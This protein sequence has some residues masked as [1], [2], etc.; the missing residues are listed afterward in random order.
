MF[1]RANRNQKD[2][3][4]SDKHISEE[5]H[6]DE[7]INLNTSIGNQA[8]IENIL[9]LKKFE[10]IIPDPDDSGSEKGSDSGNLI[11]NKYKN[12]PLLDLPLLNP[13]PELSESKKES[14]HIKFN[15]M[16]DDDSEDNDSLRQENKPDKSG[17]GFIAGIIASV[18]Q[19]NYGGSDEIEDNISEL[20]PKAGKKK[21][22]EDTE[23]N[24]L[25]IDTGPKKEE[26]EEIL[27]E[28]A[29]SQNLL[30]PGE[31]A[32]PEGQAGDRQNPPGPNEFDDSD[33][34]GTGST[35]DYKLSYSSADEKSEKYISN[36]K[37]R[38]PSKQV[39]E[40]KD[41]VEGMDA[42]DPDKKWKEEGLEYIR[43]L[44]NT[45][46]DFIGK[47]MKRLKNWNFAAQRMEDT[48]KNV[49]G[50]RKFLS[51]LSWGAGLTI[52]KILP[53]LSLGPVFKYFADKRAKKRFS[54]MQKKR[55]HDQI[56]GWNGRKFDP[57]ADKG[58]D[59]IADFRRVPTVWS[60]LTAEKAE[61]ENGKPLDP[62]ISIMISQPKAGSNK[63]MQGRNVGHAMLGIEYS[64]FSRMTGR[65]ERYDLQ[66]GFYPSANYA[67]RPSTIMMGLY[68]D[69]VVPGQL[70]DDAGHKYDISR[71]YPAKQRQVNEIF[72]AS[73][74]YADKGYQIYNRNCTTFVKEMVVD[75]AHLAI[76]DDVFKMTEVRKSSMGNLG[77][78][79]ASSV[80]SNAMAGASNIFMDNR[81]TYDPT[82]SGFG[83][84]QATQEEFT[85]YQ[86][87]LKNE[88]AHSHM[89]YSPAQTGENLRRASGEHEGQIGSYHY[90]KPLLDA[91]GDRI[92]SP[93]RLK[94]AATDMGKDLMELVS[95]VC[96]PE[97]R[98]E[99]PSEAYNTML[100]LPA[101]GASMDPI[102]R[103]IDD[104]TKEKKID[105]GDVSPSD[106][107]PDDL[108]RST[109]QEISENIRLVSKLLTKYL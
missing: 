51:F 9:D 104:Y 70:K 75:H 73:E 46:P 96:P 22:L 12:K 11:I 64:R 84:K 1:S 10:E 82:Y 45:S 32:P 42:L 53:L 18:N 47:E 21:R 94:T 69:A 17:P 87:S 3:Q 102:D 60:H 107:L 106:A 59:V 88:G 65:Y 89:T 28:M 66:Y 52:G 67:D 77:L 86:E 35:Y 4:Q 26:Q 61:D 57:N 63:T 95:T 71:T 43:K 6:A 58:K 27:N 72:K 83:N 90:D 92:T 98:T 5:A 41:T 101:M 8:M 50:W 100:L 103:K 25:E 13:D 109:R 85:R 91:E 93:Y 36:K 44:G 14:P 40:R 68:K 49:S 80:T 99:M 38:K 37:K 29:K 76:S 74:K 16:N 39:N 31:I 7:I 20:F 108:I 97:M 34:D 56:P 24:L 62:K 48:P 78:F 81:K 54:D 79:G 15:I 33:D 2:K 19:R 23:E 55:Q 105:K 30:Q